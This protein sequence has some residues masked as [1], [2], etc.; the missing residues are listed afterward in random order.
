MPM[1]ESEHTEVPQTQFH[2]WTQ[3]DKS[4]P[5]SHLKVSL[6]DHHIELAKEVSVPHRQVH[7]EA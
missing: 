6:V 5:L 2:L 1:H 3:D 7:T 4:Q